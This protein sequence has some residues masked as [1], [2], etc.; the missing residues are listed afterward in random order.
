MSLDIVSQKDLNKERHDVEG[1]IEILELDSADYKEKVELAKAWINKSGIPM[2]FKSRD[3]D[4]LMMAYNS[5]SKDMQ[6]YSDQ[7]SKELFNLDNKQ[8]FTMITNFGGFIEREDSGEREEN[9][10]ES[11][12]F[13]KRYVNFDK[14]IYKDDVM[15][16]MDDKYMY[17]IFSYSSGKFSSLIRSV[18]NDPF[19]H[20]SLSFDSKFS[21]MVSFLVQSKMKVAKNKFSNTEGLV[22]E[23]P[24]LTYDTNTKFEMYKVKMSKSGKKDILA[25]IMD[26]LDKG[27]NYNKLLLLR[28][29]LLGRHFE[30]RQDQPYSLVCSQ[31]VIMA[32]NAGGINPVGKAPEFVRPYDILKLSKKSVVKFHSEGYIFDAYIDRNK[33]ILPNNFVYERPENPMK[34]DI[35]AWINK[36]TLTLLPI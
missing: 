21:T 9:L 28:S 15:K 14:K 23:N 13:S 27:S 25:F 18:T 11:F 16:T 7:K 6:V 4:N 8:H 17:I 31:F 36:Q 29:M 1:K 10:E 30:R 32:L 35:R 12:F 2:V 22:R 20:V 33:D 19:S 34:M 26:I 24:L 3:A 5:L